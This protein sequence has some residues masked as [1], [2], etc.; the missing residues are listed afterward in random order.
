MS[1]IKLIW[2]FKKLDATNTIYRT[3]ACL[4]LVT[5]LLTFFYSLTGRG[6]GSIVPDAPGAETHCLTKTLAKRVG[7]YVEQY[8]EDMEKVIANLD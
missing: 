4:N 7:K 1:N 3:T 5:V 2:N 8:L 6:Y